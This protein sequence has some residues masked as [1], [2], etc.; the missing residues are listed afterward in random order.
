[1]ILLVTKRNEWFS[2]LKD[3]NRINVNYRQAGF[4]MK[5]QENY[6]NYEVGL[7][8]E[9]TAQDSFSSFCLH[10]SYASECNLDPGKKI[11]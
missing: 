1:M 6:L 5:C 11:R 2:V 8:L 3:W 4:W 9:P 7:T 10:T